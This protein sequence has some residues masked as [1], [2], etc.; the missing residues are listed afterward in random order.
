MVDMCQSSE[1]NRVF[2]WFFLFLLFG[3]FPRP[4]NRPMAA[5]HNWQAATANSV[6]R[7]TSWIQ[8]SAPEK[9]KNKSKKKKH[10]KERPSQNTHA[11]KKATKTVDA[12]WIWFRRPP[13][14]IGRHTR[15]LSIGLLLMVR[16]MVVFFSSQRL[17]LTPHS[18]SLS[19]PVPGSIIIMMAMSSQVAKAAGRRYRTQSAARLRADIAALLILVSSRARSFSV[20]I[21]SA[22][23]WTPPPPTPPHSWTPWPNQ[24]NRTGSYPEMRLVLLLIGRLGGRPSRFPKKKTKKKSSPFWRRY[25]RVDR[26]QRRVLGLPGDIIWISF[27]L[28]FRF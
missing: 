25:F 17:P 5:P 7:A 12:E 9:K 14:R 2:F 10:S 22:P 21:Y 18:L 28:R 27:G 1:G 24:P 23:P 19:L 8:K 6:K 20:F 3:L 4:T 13:A 15:A 26:R 11:R 16:R